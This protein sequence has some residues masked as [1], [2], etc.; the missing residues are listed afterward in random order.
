[1]AYKADQSAITA[2]DLASERALIAGLKAITPGAEV[3]GEEGIEADP[4]L[5]SQIAQAQDVWIVD[6]ID[7]TGAFTRGDPTYGIVAA[8]VHRGRT[9]QSYLYIPGVT[10]R[11]GEVIGVR[12]ELMVVA[13][14]N[15]GCFLNGERVSLAKRALSIERARISFAARNQDQALE[16]VL[17]QNVP[18][19]L[20]RHNSAFD[21]A[22]LLRGDRDAVF[23]S[24]GRN[25][26]DA[27]KCP[28]WDHAAGVLAV[29]EAGG[30]AALP[31]SWFGLPYSP[32]QRYDR[33]LVAASPLLWSS[34][35]EHVLARAP[36]LC[37]PHPRAAASLTQRLA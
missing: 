16:A 14:E 18:G 20:K 17:A 36:A 9:V 31:Y 8:L 13:R 7:G 28:P 4:A 5:F 22:S 29:T 19:Y 33:L 26:A 27:G 37:A 34:V 32:L 6:P 1:L 15:E 21:Y 30:Y 2:H 11:G 10:R 12:H 24:E 35:Y 23:Y 3:V 25:S